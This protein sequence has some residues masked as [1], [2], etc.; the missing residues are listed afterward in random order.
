MSAGWLIEPGDMSPPGAMQ[1]MMLRG[2]V[3]S[4]G[5]QNVSIAY[6]AGYQL[7]DEAC[8]APARPLTGSSPRSL[9]GPTPA[10]AA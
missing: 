9:M 3:F 7:V 1:T 10:T 8:L 2:G 4:R 5:W 6:R